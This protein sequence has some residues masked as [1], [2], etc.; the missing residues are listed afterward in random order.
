VLP[1][2]TTTA[3]TERER[4]RTTKSQK[5]LAAAEESRGRRTRTLAIVGVV[6]VAIMGVVLVLVLRDDDSASGSAAAE[7]E[8]PT[9]APPA[10]GG[11]ATAPSAA[12]PPAPP[13][14][15]A[16]AAAEPLAAVDAA[17]AALVAQQGDAGAGLVAAI[18]DAGPAAPAQ[19]ATV[20]TV[21]AH[22]GESA[23]PTPAVAHAATHPATAKAETPD[24]GAGDARPS[25]LIGTGGMRRAERGSDSSRSD[26]MV[27][28]ARFVTSGGASLKGR[29]LEA[30][31][32]R[33][34][35]GVD[36]EVRLDRQYII[37][38][39]DDAGQFN[40]PGM[41]PGSHV[42]VWVGGKRG[43]FVDE[44]TDVTIPDE[45][46]VGDAGSIRLLRGDELADR[47]DG[48]VGLFVSRRN[49]HIVVTSV[50]P[51]LPADRAGIEVG[52]ALLSVNGR[53]VSAL[54]PRAVTF[55]LRG[56]ASSSVA[57]ITQGGRDKRRDVVLQR[58]RR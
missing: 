39:A 1:P 5:T 26:D 15:A 57:I 17:V 32:D 56:P 25:P 42:V 58:V 10:A 12:R 45:G 52:D 48:W 36:V 47:M 21:V 49:G 33:P 55:L 34:I 30:E 7:A 13:P 29:V 46:Q 27:R 41:V 40:I 28:V 23:H 53:D 4:K 6:S 18:A 9:A 51:W 35:P 50:N 16:Q 20:R 54:G 44:R 14:G 3:L 31:S 38:S 37:S 2:T 24:G 43:V 22:A 19:A 11:A 8:T